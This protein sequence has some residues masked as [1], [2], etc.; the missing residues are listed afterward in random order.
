MD[1][2]NRAS[3]VIV[4]GGIVGCSLAYHLTLRGCTDVVLLERK[5]LTCGTTWHAAGLVGQLRATYNLTRLAQ[6]TTNLYASLEQE[7][8][9]ATGFRQTGSIA[10][11]TN[12]A[13]LE[14]L[15]RGASM[16]KC[17]GLEVQTLGASEIASMWPGV[18]VSDVVGGV[19]LPKDGRTNPIDTTQALAKG[20]KSRGAR[21]FEN[22]A[23]QE[24]LIEN[25]KAVG[26]RT[27]F[28]EIRADMVVNCA[29]MWAHELGA[30]AGTTVPLHA[31]EHFYIVTEPMEGLHSNMP[32]LRD[33]DGC[34]YFKED[35]GKLLVGWF[36]PVAKPWGMKGIPETFS[37]D[38]LPD[39]L[40]HIEPLLAAAMHRTPALEKTGI[41]LFFNGPESFTPDD[42]YL[43]GETP[44]VRNLFVAAGFNS[45]GIQ[46]AGGAGKVLADWMLDGHPPMDLWD[47]DIRRAMPFQ[48]N[49][50]YLRDRTVETLGLL[51]AMHWPFR[52][53]ETARGVRRSILHDRLA[54]HG[55]CFGETAGWERPNWYAPAGVKA[56]YAYSYGRQNWFD[57]SAAEHK[58][59]RTAVGIFDQSS[60]AKFLVQGPDA[61]K[62]LNHISANNMSV[63]VGKVVYTQWLNARGGI[64]AD[65]TVTRE[66]HDRYLVVTAAATQTRDFAWLQ[67]QIPADARATAVDVSSSMAVISVMGPRSR[68]L[69]RQLTDAD[70]SHTAFPFATSQVIDLGYARVRAS[71]ITYVG[72]L[73]W[74]LYIPTECTPGVFDAIMAAAPSVGG[75]LAGY[76]ALNSLR[77]EKGYRH[78]GHD[79][80]DEDTPLQGG[81]GF[82]VAM[83]KPGG[84]I[85]HAALL[86]QKDAGLTRRLVQ[87]ALVDD[88]ALL[89][90]NEPIWR[91][92][93]I[94]GRI[95]SGMFG[96]HLGKSLGMGYV[97]CAQQ[98]E[99]ADAILSGHYEVEVAGVRIPAT[100]SLTPLY[101]PTSARVKS[102]D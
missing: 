74:E 87:F 101:D 10:I 98:G 77:M 33:P 49:R 102:A 59:V 34:A 44:E 63:P 12:L 35:A 24:I 21:I 81:L 19:Y 47:V 99:P 6:Y 95:S 4:G 84:F 65:L 93:K 52:Q 61:E 50:S 83:N 78:W 64:E 73:G 96:H 18:N 71:R 54:A 7:T 70:L 55:A 16:A 11:A 42:R 36:E 23:A 8:G 20:A 27:Q 53:P 32:V 97:E 88:Q 86:A 67:R 26:V 41:N 45:I 82:A 85:G 46:S 89:Y 13:R 25:G 38:S 22:C 28:G 76:H 30:K 62:V 43:L 100:P 5:Q 14:E 37:F 51:Y 1:L 48:R 90:H 91:D 39:D 57:Y 17:F 94:V 80:S 72:E 3:V 68:E 2:P 79:I 58:A 15:K 60:F 75:R 31:A 92:N 69:L 40:E 29:G 66:A 56:E 9:Q